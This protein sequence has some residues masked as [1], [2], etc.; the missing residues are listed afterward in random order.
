MSEEERRQVLEMIESGQIT[1]EQGLALLEALQEDTEGVIPTALPEESEP[2]AETGPSAWESAARPEEVVVESQP[3]Q[4]EP[5]PAPDLSSSIKKWRSWWWIPLWVGIGITVI[6]GLLM[7]LAYQK[8]GVGF[9][10]ACTW[11]PFLVGVAVMAL[12]AASRTARWLH[13]RVQQPPGEFPQH[14]AI[15]MPIP[16]RLTAW[17]L[18]VFKG[19]I[20]ETGNVNL[21]E[22]VL[23]LE[24]VTPDAPLYVQVDEDDGERVEVY[25]G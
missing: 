3:P 23:A 15:S 25:I 19:R 2:T 13:V 12:A 1:A 24:K 8:S 10:F 17:G 16:I 5:S 7:L 18:K 9:W 22:M 20:P 21:D 11:F 14:I 4:E 6:S